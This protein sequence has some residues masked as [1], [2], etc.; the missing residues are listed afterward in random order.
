MWRETNLWGIYLPPV[1][2]YL[3][4]AALLWLPLR[5]GLEALRLDRWTW[6]TPLAEASLYVCI[7]A[8]LVAW[9]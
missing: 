3:A 1:L 7:L 2:V 8:A 6:N 9:L 4:A 5:W